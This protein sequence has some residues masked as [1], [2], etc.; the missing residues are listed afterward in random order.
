[1]DGF[2]PC[3][4]R[5]TR[6]LLAGLVVLMLGC[7]SGSSVKLQF[8]NEQG[9]TS[10]PLKG[11]RRDGLGSSG[12]TVFEMKLIAVYLAEDVEASTQNNR[13]QTAM[14][15]ENP[16]CADDIMHCSVTE[17]T[18]ED[19]QPFTHVIRDF[20]NFAAD[21]SVVNA[22]LN[23]QAREIPEGT[24][25][26]A[27]MEFCKYGAGTEPNIRWAAPGVPLRGFTANQC[28]VTSA[29]MDP[30]LQVTSGQSLEVTLS[31]DLS[32]TVT[33]RTMAVGFDCARTDSGS[34]V[35]FDLPQFT[36]SATIR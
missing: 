13:G 10:Q 5:M 25:R 6:A 23:A 29:V 4:Q 22:A 31:Y 11:V 8:L 33:E 1:M 18:A 9:A 26:Y 21:S 16:T 36:P 32:T 28:G 27:R 34:Y 17:G 35:C 2:L 24:Y 12:P 30:P 19:G 15:Y 3:V 7:G 20:F 14:I